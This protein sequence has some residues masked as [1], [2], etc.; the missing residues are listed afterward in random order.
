MRVCV[1]HSSPYRGFAYGPLAD[2]VADLVGIDAETTPD[3]RKMLLA[4]VLAKAPQAAMHRAA[5]DILLD[6]D[7]APSGL[8][9]LSPIDRRLRIEAAAIA[10]FRSVSEQEPLILVCEDIHWL[11]E[12]SLGQIGRFWEGIRAGRSW[13]S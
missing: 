2:L 3:A 9:S 12:D 13:R 8:A 6:I 1:S 11:D 10:L 5:L 7:S 4:N